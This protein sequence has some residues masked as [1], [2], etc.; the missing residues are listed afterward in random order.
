[1]TSIGR[2]GEQHDVIDT[3]IAKPAWACR[4]LARRETARCCARAGSHTSDSGDRNQDA[5]RRSAAGRLG[6]GTIEVAGPSA[7][8]DARRSAGEMIGPVPSRP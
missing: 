1:M 8:E 3:R 2:D 5:A 6:A 7:A 4:G